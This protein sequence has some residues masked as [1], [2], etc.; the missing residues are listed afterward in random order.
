MSSFGLCYYSDGKGNCYSP[1]CCSRDNTFIS[2][3]YCSNAHCQDG[4]LGPGQWKYCFPF[5]CY[6]NYAISPFYCAN[7]NNDMPCCCHELNGDKWCCFGLAFY[8]SAKY[9]CS[10]CH[11]YNQDVCCSWAFLSCVFEYD[12][13]KYWI[14]PLA[15]SNHGDRGSE[16]K[17][18]GDC[19]YAG[20]VC[21]FR[22]DGRN[23][24]VFPGGVKNVEEWDVEK[25]G[26]FTCVGPIACC[27]CEHGEEAIPG[28]SG[29]VILDNWILDNKIRTQPKRYLVHSVGLKPIK[30]GPPL[31]TMTDEQC[32]KSLSGNILRESMM[33]TGSEPALANVIQS[34]S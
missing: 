6:E 4:D 9:N 12:G 33:K 22:Y 24:K 20:P 14:T 3:L 31:Q 29:D 32:R 18:D 2:P 7:F 8:N 5:L 17:I 26:D 10:L 25:P 11:F 1:L 15:G 28:N 23:Y 19:F 27:I 30:P 13:R 16:N 21:C 34:Y